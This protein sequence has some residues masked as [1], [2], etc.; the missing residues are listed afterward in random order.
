MDRE[1]DAIAKIRANIA[2]KSKPKPPVAT[3]ESVA[4]DIGAAMT[5]KPKSTPA[6]VIRPEPEDPPFEFS[7]DFQTKIAALMIRDEKFM[8]RIDGMVKPHHFER[9]TEAQ[10]VGL[11]IRHFDNYGQLPTSE[12]GI[13]SEIISDA[14]NKNVI[15][16]DECRELVKDLRRILSSSLS[17][18]EFVLEKVAD[19]AKKQEIMKAI[20]SAIDMAERGDYD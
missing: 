18:R 2:A 5:G 11:A 4:E 9:F 20:H 6:P 19:F 3:E 8:R 17:N 7:E 12:P 14:A 13:W 1:P 15:T 16:D 10:I